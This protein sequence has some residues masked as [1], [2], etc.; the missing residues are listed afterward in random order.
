[1]S[2]DIEGES[3][4]VRVARRTVYLPAQPSLRPRV[5]FYHSDDGFDLTALEWGTPLVSRRALLDG[6]APIVMAVQTCDGIPAAVGSGC[7]LGGKVSAENAL[8]SG[9]VITAIN[10]ERSIAA[11]DAAKLLEETLAPV[12]LVVQCVKALAFLSSNPS[13]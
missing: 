5:A 6:P 1:M 10:A 2:I 12:Q 7:L 13:V 8:W 4:H 11:L 9:D 3:G